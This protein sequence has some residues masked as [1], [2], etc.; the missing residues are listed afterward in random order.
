[1]EL[2]YQYFMYVKILAHICDHVKGFYGN[3]WTLP[4]VENE[5]R[6][7]GLEHCVIRICGVRLVD[8]VSTEV[9]WDR[10]GIVVKIEDVIIQS[11]L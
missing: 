6:L 1:M 5:A 11:H 9:L 3:C 8:R 7:H 10:V 4:T 2:R